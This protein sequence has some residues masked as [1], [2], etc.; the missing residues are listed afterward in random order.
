MAGREERSG[1][2]G[3]HVLR[4]VTDYSANDIRLDTTEEAVLGLGRCQRAHELP[5]TATK[6]AEALGFSSGGGSGS[7]AKS[8]YLPPLASVGA[9]LRAPAV[10]TQARP[11][12]LDAVQLHGLAT[13]AINGTR[14]PRSPTAK[15]RP[16]RAL[17]L[18][19]RAASPSQSPDAPSAPFSGFSPSG[20]DVSAISCRYIGGFGET[21]GFD[22]P[23]KPK[24]L[25]GTPA[26][27][28]GNGKSSGM[29]RQAAMLLFL[30]V[31]GGSDRS[32]APQVSEITMRAMQRRIAAGGQAK[33]MHGYTRQKTYRERLAENRRRYMTDEYARLRVAKEAREAEAR[34]IAEA[35]QAEQDRIK[36]DYE[37][38]RARAL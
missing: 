29:V 3:T 13:P 14:V 9:D 30:F 6:A 28:D 12:W 34:R 35:E 19:P 2:I 16:V 5:E 33:S 26:P 1:Q 27:S 36:Q 22:S 21:N 32:S 15:Y 23:N 25:G 37:E 8:P 18:P 11:T 10:E 17:S 31:A 38:R 4:R 7:G 20:G 24:H